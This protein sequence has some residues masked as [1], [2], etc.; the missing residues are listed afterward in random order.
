MYFHV[1]DTMPGIPPD[2]LERIF[3][4][5]TQVDS[6]HTGSRGGSGP[7]LPVSQRLARLLGGDLEVE[8]TVGQGSCF[9]LSL[10]LSPPASPPGAAE[11][12]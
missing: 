11:G 8:S 4:P 2:Y 10:P 5:F 9:T 6:S 1:R 7:G 12:R 3:E